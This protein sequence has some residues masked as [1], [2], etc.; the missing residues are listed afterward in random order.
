MARG[1][2]GV[3]KFGSDFT[4]VGLD[5]QVPA[6]TGV[7]SIGNGIGLCG[8]NEGTLTFTVDEPGGVI[9]LT[10]DTG[11][12]DNVCLVAG[13]FKPVDGGMWMEARF[14][15]TSSVAATRSSVF[16]G[17]TETLSVTTPVMPV[18]RSGTT[19]TFNGTGGVLGVLFDSDST[20]LRFFACAAD[21]GA[22]LAA[23]NSKTGASI[24]TGVLDLSNTMTADRW[25]VVRVEIGTN[26]KGRVYFGDIDSGDELELV[27]ENTTALGTGDNF[28]AVLMTETRVI[29]TSNIMEA[30]YFIGEG[31]RDWAVD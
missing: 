26:G 20:I 4:G 1:S 16:C 10:T 25:Y 17:F 13:V 15:I 31:Y 5:A 6:A 28:H 19:N 8:V 27:F 2:L 12:D 24:T 9:A 7:H 29:T 14:K 30:D 23:K 11:D 21:G 18:E 3:I 22:A